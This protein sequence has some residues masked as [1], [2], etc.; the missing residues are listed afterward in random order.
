MN[1]SIGIIVGVVVI[2]GVGYFAFTR[3]ETETVCAEEICT[4]DTAPEQIAGDDAPV[5]IGDEDERGD[6]ETT[7]NNPGE[8][9]TAGGSFE[10]Y[11]A[12]QVAAA[13]GDVVIFFHASW[14]PSCR[15]L[16]TNIEENVASI[17][18]GTTI[19]KA[20]F[21]TETELKK[22]Y[23]VTTQHTLVQIDKDG[24]LI[25]KWSGGSRLTNLLSEME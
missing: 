7:I 3:G 12:E 17:P 25:K 2:T 8:T 6:G 15:A 4:I 21:D 16:S 24:T 20:D 13:P 23:G 22:K 18:A 19:L 9:L 14:C 5:I 11:S 10:T 1:K